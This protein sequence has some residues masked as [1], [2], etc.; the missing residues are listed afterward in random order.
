MQFTN[1]NSFP[2]GQ[3]GN[4]PANRRPDRHGNG[5]AARNIDGNHNGNPDGDRY[6]DTHAQTQ[7]D[8]IACSPRGRRGHRHQ[9]LVHGTTDCVLF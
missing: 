7:F 4:R 6:N 2:D 5:D 1:S 9:R 3:T 8:A